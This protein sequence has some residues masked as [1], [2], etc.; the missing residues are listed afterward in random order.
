MVGEAT[1]C[2]LAVRFIIGGAAVS[3]AAVL[4][5]QLH[6]L[7]PQ[8]S[9]DAFFK[10]WWV[11]DGISDG[12]WVVL[13]GS[14]RLRWTRFLGKLISVSN[15]R[16]GLV[17]VVVVVSQR[18]GHVGL[19]SASAVVWWLTLAVAV[20]LLRPSPVCVLLST[21]CG[22]R[23]SVLGDLSVGSCASFCYPGCIGVDPKL[24]HILIRNM[25]A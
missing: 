5:A 25:K 20:L 22:C 21:S 13:Q 7:L 18:S 2:E 17:V 15:C 9:F 19:W 14:G 12:V 8:R 11:M 10:V 6:R 23:P 16:P 4:G 24:S 3:T 1:C